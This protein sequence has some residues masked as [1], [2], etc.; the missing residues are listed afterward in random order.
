MADELRTWRRPTPRVRGPTVPSS[1]RSVNAERPYGR[2]TR[3]TGISLSPI[4]SERKGIQTLRPPASARARGTARAQRVLDHAVAIES[5]ILAAAVAAMCE[6][7]Y[8]GT[9]V[10]EIAERAGMSVANVYHYF[11]S[12]QEI[13]FRIMDENVQ[14]A[15]DEIERTVASVSSGAGACVVAATQA[16]AAMNATRRATAFVTST[17]LRALEPAARRTIVAKRR[18][19]QELFVELVGAGRASGEFHIHDVELTTRMLLDMTRSLADWYRPD[20]RLGVDELSAA[21][22]DAA[23]AIVG[24]KRP[25][26]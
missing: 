10:R 20:G 21:Y 7:G 24:A 26:A 9:S 15:I 2:N 16:F 19:I 22:A 8:H 11:E 23:L 18:R 13:L 12:K 4:V 6:N 1:D 5:E 17:E 3:Q 25:P 14:D